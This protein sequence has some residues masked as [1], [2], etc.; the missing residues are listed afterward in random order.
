MALGADEV[1][2]ATGRMGLLVSC[3]NLEEFFSEKKNEEL[4]RKKRCSTTLYN[5]GEGTLFKGQAD[6]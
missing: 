3:G 6:L 1:H 2:A 4:K 5:C